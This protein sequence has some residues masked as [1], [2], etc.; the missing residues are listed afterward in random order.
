M[1]SDLFI[2]R[3]YPKYDHKRVT[4]TE[5][6]INSRDGYEEIKWRNVLAK[7]RLVERIK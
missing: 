6:A 3:H 7:L 4:V 1:I 2:I 5:C